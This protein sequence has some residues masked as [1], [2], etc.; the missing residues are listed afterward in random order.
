MDEMV[1]DELDIGFE[2]SINGV[3]DVKVFIPW[4]MRIRR[5]YL[6]KLRYRLSN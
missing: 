6:A 1:F 3:R 2:S 5:W 4:G